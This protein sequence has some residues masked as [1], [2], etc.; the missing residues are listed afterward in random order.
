M[1]RQGIKW[2][3]PFIN[4]SFRILYLRSGRGIFSGFIEV[5]LTVL[6]VGIILFPIILL[7]GFN[8]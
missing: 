6:I 4:K 2:L 3:Y 7:G 5:L 8:V 1:T